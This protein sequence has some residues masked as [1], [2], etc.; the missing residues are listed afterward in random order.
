MSYASDMNTNQNNFVLAVSALIIALSVGY[1]FVIFLPQKEQEKI[2]LQ[3]QK[4]EA[5][6]NQKSTNSLRLST[7]F[8]NAETNFMKLMELNSVSNPQPSY[9]DARKW[10][11][12][13]IKE[14]TTDQYNKEKELCIKLYSE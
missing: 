11:S 7:C 8:D 1:Y 13:E 12:A 3:K 2:D 4:Q 9:P 14:S 6:S 10:N 5:L